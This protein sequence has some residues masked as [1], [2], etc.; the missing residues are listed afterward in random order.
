LWLSNALKLYS[1]FDVLPA[2]L[3]NCMRRKLHGFSLVLP[4]TCHDS[5]KGDQLCFLRVLC[6]C[7]VPLGGIG[8]QW[9]LSVS[10]KAEWQ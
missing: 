9:K 3:P 7:T 5:Q 8:G 4:S 6:A 2:A 1:D 10:S